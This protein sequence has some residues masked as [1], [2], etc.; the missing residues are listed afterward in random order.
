MADKTTGNVPVKD[1]DPGGTKGAPHKGQAQR[2]EVESGD[3]N[4]MG[5]EP[6]KGPGKG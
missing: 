4:E 1:T 5:K 2:P 3:R 6:E